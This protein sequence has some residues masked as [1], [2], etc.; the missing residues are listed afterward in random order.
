MEQKTCCVTGH[1][2]LTSTQSMTAVVKLMEELLMAANE[3]YTRFMTG[4]AEGVDQLFARNVL[5]IKK[6]SSDIKLVAAI[7]HRGRL[8]TKDKRFQEL[9]L[10][11]DEVLVLSERYHPGVYAARNRWMLENSG[12]LIAVWDGRL[13]GG[14]YRTVKLAEKLG[15][16]TRRVN[17]DY[18]DL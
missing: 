10:L 11:C 13:T 2:S 1:R 17:P 12:R 8:A 14:T 16:D 3:G 5:L 9:I 6:Y 18:P 7:S 15:I 4:M